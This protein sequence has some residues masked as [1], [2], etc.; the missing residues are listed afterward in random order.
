MK[1]TKKKQQGILTNYNNNILT[2]IIAGLIVY[3]MIFVYN[4][5]LEIITIPFPFNVII[6]FLGGILIFILLYWFFV[7]R[8]IRRQELI[9]SAKP[10][11]FHKLKFKKRNNNG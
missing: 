11:K 4:L 9:W 8:P 2:G 6:A 3:A 7:T 1:P 10:V 5:I